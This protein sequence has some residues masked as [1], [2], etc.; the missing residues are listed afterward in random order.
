M[1]SYRH[2]HVHTWQHETSGVPC[3]IQKH[4]YIV[5]SLGVCNFTKFMTRCLLIIFICLHVM[6]GCEYEGTN[7]I[8]YGWN[9]GAL[10]IVVFPAYSQPSNVTDVM[11]IST[12]TT[13]DM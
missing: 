7:I 8:Y 5:Y 2:I 3:I 1:I 11:L 10:Y 4:T 12:S 9:F 13:S 6:P